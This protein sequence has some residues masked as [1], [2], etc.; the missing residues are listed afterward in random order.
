MFVDV[1]TITAAF[2]ERLTTR[3]VKKTFLADRWPNNGRDFVT[4]LRLSVCRL[5]VL[6]PN[7]TSYRKKLSEEKA[8]GLPA[9]Y[10]AIP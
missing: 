8:I 9:L 2:T 10:P 5:F 6:W 3:C 4:R 7:S 1:L